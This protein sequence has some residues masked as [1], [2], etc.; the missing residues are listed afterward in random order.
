[1]YTVNIPDRHSTHWRQWGFLP[2]QLL[3]G[4]AW[5]VVHLKIP[6]ILLE[7]TA[8]LSM[9]VKVTLLSQPSCHWYVINRAQRPKCRQSDCLSMTALH[10]HV[11]YIHSITQIC[12]SILFYFNNMHVI[13]VH[14]GRKCELQKRLLP[15]VHRVHETWNLTGWHSNIPIMTSQ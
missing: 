11:W 14:V 9:V 2:L 12:C 3:K 7:G 8:N 15:T 6:S 4:G 1:M 13:Y 5:S 10:V